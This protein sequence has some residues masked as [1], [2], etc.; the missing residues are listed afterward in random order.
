MSG[1]TGLE[2]LVVD[3]D[4]VTRNLLKEVLFKEGYSVSLAPSGEAAIRILS[5]SKNSESGKIFPLLLSDIRM[6]EVTGLELLKTV[7]KISG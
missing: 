1:G 2:I 5:E 7:K 6:L 4:E 3:D